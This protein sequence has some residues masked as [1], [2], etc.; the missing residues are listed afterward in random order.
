MRARRVAGPGGR[1]GP[2][3]GP[4]PSQI[5]WKQSGVSLDLDRP[6]MAEIQRGNGLAAESLRNRD[7]GPVCQLQP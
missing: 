3:D 4:P 2:N 1:I 5:P 7:D 6:E